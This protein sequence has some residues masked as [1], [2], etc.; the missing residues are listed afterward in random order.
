MK[1]DNFGPRITY[2]NYN[3]TKN[4]DHL[5]QLIKHDFENQQDAFNDRQ[6]H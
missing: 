1:Q 5:K 3:N 6:I 2:K 4:N